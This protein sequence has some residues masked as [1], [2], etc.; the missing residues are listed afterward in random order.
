VTAIKI[1]T[2]TIWHR[3]D[4]VM[5]EK[6]F[7][8]DADVVHLIAETDGVPTHWSVNGGRRLPIRE[9]LHPRKYV[10]GDTVRISLKLKGDEI[11][12]EELR[13][14]LLPKLTEARRLMAGDNHHN[15]FK[16]VRMIEECNQLV[17]EM[18]GPTKFTS[19]DQ[20]STSMDR[21][22]AGISLVYCSTRGW[23]EYGPEDLEEGFREAIAALEAT[24]L[25]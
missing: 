11:T 7:A 10:A 6:G 23:H 4:Q 2:I 3:G 24:G 22:A 18:H 19:D 8:A 15:W 12:D 1:K 5:A 25:S 17:E 14:I 21:A 13:A 9:H 20:H 16:G